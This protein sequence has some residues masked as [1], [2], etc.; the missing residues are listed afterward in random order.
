MQFLIYGAT[1]ICLQG[2]LKDL[3]TFKFNITAYVFIFKIINYSFLVFRNSYP[4][5]NK[6][7]DHLKTSG[8][9]VFLPTLGSDSK[10][11]KVKSKKKKW[12]KFYNNWNIQWVP[13]KFLRQILHPW[14]VQFNAT[15]YFYFYVWHSISCSVQVRLTWL[16]CQP[17]GLL[18]CFSLTNQ[19][20]DFLLSSLVRVSNKLRH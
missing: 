10:Q 13:W 14:S 7:Y 11:S 3:S 5:K 4:S 16:L 6:L 20:A 19:M 2:R 8:H 9:A 17:M 12:I 18:H 15:K 1:F